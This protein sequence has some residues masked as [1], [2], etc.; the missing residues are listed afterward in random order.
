MGRLSRTFSFPG[1][2]LSIRIERSIL[3]RA[4]RFFLCIRNGERGQEITANLADEF[5]NNLKVLAAIGDR[6]SVDPNGYMVTPFYVK[7]M[8]LFMKQQPKLSLKV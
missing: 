1:L 6:Y 5:K 8:K 3:P 7:L 4:A 2:K